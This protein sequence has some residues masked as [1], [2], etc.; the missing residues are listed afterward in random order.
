MKTINCFDG[1]YSFLS[2]FYEKDF[3]LNGIT[4]KTSEHAFQSI[5]AKYPD[6][7][8]QVREA[9]TPGQAKRLGRK[10]DL[11]DG[12]NESRVAVMTEIIRAKFTSD[13]EMRDKLL[14]TADALLIE[15]NYWHDNF[16]GDCSC[17]RCSNKPGLNNL[18]KIL[19]LVRAGL[20]AEK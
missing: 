13:Q 18:G 5:K 15:G 16:W 4:Y 10:V 2:N 7:A 1:E 12:W 8:K 6:Q 20:A 11:V 14:S 17:S 3:Q 9:A 19:M